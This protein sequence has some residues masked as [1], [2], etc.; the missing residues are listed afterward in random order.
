MSLTSSVTTRTILIVSD[1]TCGAIAWAARLE[2]IEIVRD[3]REALFES[4]ILA[5]LRKSIHE[6]IERDRAVRLLHGFRPAQR[7]PAPIVSRPSIA[8]NAGA[9]LRRMRRSCGLA[10]ART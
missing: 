7:L 1:P 9:H 2:E 4:L 8:L 5:P 3:V 10:R 6:F